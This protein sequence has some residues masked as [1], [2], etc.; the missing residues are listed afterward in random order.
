MPERSVWKEAMPVIVKARNVRHFH[1][2]LSKVNNRNYRI[3]ALLHRILFLETMNSS[4]SLSALFLTC[5]HGKRYNLCI[6]KEI[7]GGR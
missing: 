3:R 7:S 6:C 5:I 4:T 2:V 1:I